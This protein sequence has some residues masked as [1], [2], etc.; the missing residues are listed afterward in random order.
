MFIQFRQINNS[1]KNLTKTSLCVFSVLLYFQ[2]SLFNLF[3]D[4]VAIKIDNSLLNTFFD[5]LYIKFKYVTYCVLN[6]NYTFSNW[7]IKSHKKN[8][9]LL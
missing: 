3:I 8:Y 4:F 5:I 6:L 1:L 2:F 7:L 9:F